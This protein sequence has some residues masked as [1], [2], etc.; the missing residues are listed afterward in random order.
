M[1]ILFPLLKFNRFQKKQAFSG[2][3]LMHAFIFFVLFQAV[4]SLILPPGAS[5]NNPANFQSFKPKST[6]ISLA[7]ENVKLHSNVTSN[8]SKSL[9]EFKKFKKF[10]LENLSLLTNSLSFERADFPNQRAPI[11]TYKFSRLNVLSSQAHP[12]T[13]V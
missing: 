9:S 7:L 6:T 8:T 1:N 2:G 4:F 3:L 13:V 11:H 10:P 12:P 5:Q